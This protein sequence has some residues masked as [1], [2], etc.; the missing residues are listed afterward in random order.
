MKKTSVLLVLSALMSFV[1]F[2]A[3]AERADAGTVEVG[4]NLM[5]DTD[6]VAGADWT[7][8]ALLGYFWTDG[9]MVSGE[10]RL[11]DNDYTTLYSAVAGV[12]KSF[13]VGSADT[14][15]PFIPYVGAGVGFASASFENRGKKEEE[16][17]RDG[18]AMILEFKGGLKVMLT[19]DL[20]LDVGVYCDLATDDVYFDKDGPS[21]TDVSIRMGLRTFLF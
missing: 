10:F 1:P 13:E 3:A 5:Y 6:T 21:K 12:E 8:G 16:E 14:I 7:L 20:A 15:T 11:E 18:T 4:L 2:R 17:D 19:G 9:W